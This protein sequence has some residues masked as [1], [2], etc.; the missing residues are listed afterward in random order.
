MDLE[1]T[2]DRIPGDR[3]P[4]SQHQGGHSSREGP[5]V[6]CLPWAGLG[7]SHRQT[8]ACCLMVR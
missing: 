5:D 6:A 7:W 3:T 2:A 8:P 4:T 1:G